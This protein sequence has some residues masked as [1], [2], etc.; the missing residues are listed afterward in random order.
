M[1]TLKVSRKAQADLRTIGRYTAKKWG[2][3]QRNRYLRELDLCF[4]TLAKH[5]DLGRDIGDL[6]P[7]YYRH[8]HQSHIV[9]YIKIDDGVRIV[10]VLHQRMDY[11]RH[12]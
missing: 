5:P 3:Q 9:F 4:Q 10:R 12:L 1:P 11:E 6:R 7:G 2:A 8:R